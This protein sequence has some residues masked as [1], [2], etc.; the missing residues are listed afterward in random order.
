MCWEGQGR[1]Q[2][3]AVEAR[4]PLGPEQVLSAGPQGADT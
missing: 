4:L 3:Q 1:A 2:M